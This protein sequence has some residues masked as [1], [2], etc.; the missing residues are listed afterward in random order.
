MF[1]NFTDRART[2]FVL[3]NQQA[4]LFNVEGDYL[5]PEHVALGLFKEGTANAISVLKNLGV[6]IHVLNAVIDKSIN[7]GP[8]RIMMGKLPLHPRTKTVV[9]CSIEESRMM[10]H[11]YV[12]TEH[13]LIGLMRETESA[14]RKF[15][16]SIDMSVDVVRAEIHKLLKQQDDA[17]VSE[18]ERILSDS[19][20][21][22]RP[23]HP[24][25]KILSIRDC[26]AASAMQ[27]IVSQARPVDDASADKWISHVCRLSYRIADGMIIA[28]ESVALPP[29]K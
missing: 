18:A 27:G 7:R 16:L 2:V 29:V 8:D 14:L 9:E 13:I 21:K 24:S 23:F 4:H 6:N 12:G 1:E 15:M 17:D 20:T 19:D 26:F 22:V 11:H 28:R 5:T 25:G 10:G 3:A